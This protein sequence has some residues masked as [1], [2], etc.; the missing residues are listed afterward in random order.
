[1]SSIQLF[2]FQASLRARAVERTESVPE[3]TPVQLLRAQGPGGS[4]PSMRD[5]T[6]VFIFPG[7]CLRA[8]RRPSPGA[9]RT[10][11]AEGAP[12]EQRERPQVE[13][14]P[15]TSLCNQCAQCRFHSDPTL[16]HGRGVRSR[17][18]P[19]RPRAERAQCLQSARAPAEW[20][21][22]PARGS[23]GP[24]C[25]APRGAWKGL[26]TRLRAP[27]AGARRGPADAGRREGSGLEPVP[28]SSGFVH[29]CEES[30]GPLFPLLNAPAPPR[31]EFSEP[32]PPN[33]PPLFL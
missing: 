14:R 17:W 22:P 16:A 1:M 25:A 30:S 9:D 28:R 27:P 2:Y 29:G 5:F 33:S 4:G 8:G 23:A 13:T 11:R 31:P 20:P 3:K 7:R 15:H 21:R 12:T 6:N 18:E 26:Q 24:H 10:H 32:S 19:E